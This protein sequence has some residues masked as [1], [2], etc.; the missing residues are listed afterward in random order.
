M[1]AFVGDR[2]GRAATPANPDYFARPAARGAQRVDIW[3]AD[4]APPETIAEFA[5]SVIRN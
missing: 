3:F 4:F 2:A 5:G 1:V